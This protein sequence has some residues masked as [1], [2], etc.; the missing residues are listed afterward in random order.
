[1]TKPRLVFMG[2]PDF[3]VPTLDQLVKD[4][5]DIALVVSQPDRK[6]SRN[7][8]TPTPVKA[9]ALELGLDV[10]TPE[11]V[12]TDEAVARIAGLEPDFIVVVAYGQIIRQALLDVCPGRILNLHASLL[13]K[14]RGAAPI[15]R[16]I[17]EGE[18]ETGVTVMR[19]EKGLDTGL[20]YK[21]AR[22][23]IDPDEDAQSLTDRLAL[24]GAPLMAEV[25][26]NFDHYAA[27]AQVQDDS[28]ATYAAMLSRDERTIDW[29]RPAQAI[30][31][32]VRGLKPWPGTQ[33][34]LDG[35][36]VKIHK[37]SIREG[38]SGHENGTLVSIEGEGVLVQTGQGQLLITEWQLPGKR[39]V[40][41]ADYLRGNPLEVG[42]RLM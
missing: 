14:Y 35:Q 12:N 39:P 40:A 23:P 31:D 37:T 27:Q 33:T 38:Y 9:R 34:T 20:M 30:H 26:G 16:A 18:K 21:K 4:G 6:R 3:A 5:F 22:T 29:N 42:T 17:M 24:M 10:M 2:S 7:K 19:I 11:N 41:L 28:R 25:L 32:Q 15:N 8:W 1:M 13:P 36:V